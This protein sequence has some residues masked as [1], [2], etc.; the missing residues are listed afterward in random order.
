MTFFVVVFLT[1][2][3]K[4]DAAVEPRVTTTGQGV[5]VDPTLS[6]EV[7]SLKTTLAS[8]QGSL[9]TSVGLIQDQLDQFGKQYLA[10]VDSRLSAIELKIAS[11]EDSVTRLNERALGWETLQH[12]VRSWGDQMTS[13]DTKVDHLGRTQMD[14]LTTLTGQ[15]NSLQSG[16]TL[17]I[18]SIGDQLTAMEGRL[19]RSLSDPDPHIM[20]SLQRVEAKVTSNRPR[21]RI[22]S[23][24]NRTGICTDLRKDVNLLSSNVESLVRKSRHGNPDKDHESIQ[25]ISMETTQ[26][27]QLVKIIRKVALPF[28]KANK[29]LRD[30][31]DIGH[32][33]EATMGEIRSHVHVASTDI[34]RKFNDFFNMTLEMFEHQHHQMEMSEEALASLKQSCRGTTSDLSS[35]RAKAEPILSKVEA[36]VLAA[37][38]DGSWS[39]SR[40]QLRFDSD[41]ILAVLKE[42]ENILID[43]FDNCVVNGNGSMYRAVPE[44]SSIST[45][46]TS[47]TT[48]PRTTTST[49]P[50]PTWRR[51]TV[52]PRDARFES[53]T[54]VSAALTEG[55]AVS[56]GNAEKMLQ[57]CEQLL[58]AGFLDNKVYTV[59]LSEEDMLR[60]P[61]NLRDFRQRY[62]DQTTSGGG[63]TVN[64]DDPVRPALRSPFVIVVLLLIIL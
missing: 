6:A 48:T 9:I 36:F 61:S 3:L 59:E 60:D 33:L 43:G 38:R 22:S 21:T 24:P 49:T 27:Q 64:R 42:Q 32:H 39:R 13:L 7:A 28:K 1:A 52:S 44:V 35:F 30:M 20:S 41:R 46:T 34:D 53:G 10:S 16:L 18:E 62:C 4:S 12:H 15:V 11:F 37:E 5:Y 58:E 50:T 56:V 31:E 51:T 63:W 26:E 47:T 55:A 57:T 19:Q 17:S 23:H 45:T 25:D 2:I 54:V 14:R 40:E 8:V 29:R